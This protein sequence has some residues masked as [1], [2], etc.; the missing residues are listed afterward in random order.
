MRVSLLQPYSLSNAIITC[1]KLMVIRIALRQADSVEKN[2]MADHSNVTA[3]SGTRKPKNYAQKYKDE[4]Q[5][6]GL[7]LENQQKD[8]A[9]RSA[10]SVVVILA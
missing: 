7:V 1:V 5:K 6:N 2:N 10:P 8:K 9:M 4:Y 3:T